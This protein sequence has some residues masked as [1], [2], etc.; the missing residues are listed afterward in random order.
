MAEW[1]DIFGAVVTLVI[2][3]LS[4]L[5]FVFRLIGRMGLAKVA[6][7]FN[8]AMSFPLGYL[9]T[10]AQQQERE[11]LYYIQIGLMLVWMGRTICWQARVMAT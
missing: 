6:G 11:T 7:G 8:L 9:L 10:T 3:L 5:V 1:I 4:I 2:Y